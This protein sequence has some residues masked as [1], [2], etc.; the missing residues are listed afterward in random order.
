MKMSIM[1]AGENVFTCT[2]SKNFVPYEREETMLNTAYRFSAFFFIL[3]MFRFYSIWYHENC[4]FIEWNNKKHFN[5]V[6]KISCETCAPSSFAQTPISKMLKLKLVKF[7]HLRIIKPFY[8]CSNCCCF[9]YIFF[10]S[11]TS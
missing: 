10:C 9:S 11:V 6:Q 2:S 4:I 7:W 3:L 1:Y 8:Y 5:E